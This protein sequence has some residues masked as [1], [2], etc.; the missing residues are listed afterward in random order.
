[1]KRRR[2][3]IIIIVE[4][5]SEMEALSN[6]I[7]VLFDDYY[8]GLFNVEFVITG[9]D[10][11]SE[12]G[13]MPRNIENWISVQCIQK[14]LSKM[15]LEAEDIDHIIQFTDLDGAYID[16]SCIVEDYKIDSVCYT[17]DCIRAKKKKD[18]IK[19]NERKRKNLDYLSSIEQFSIY[20]NTLKI[21]DIPYQIFFFSS[22]LDHF[23]YGEQNLDDNKK[24]SSAIDFSVRISPNEFESMLIEGGSLQRFAMEEKGYKESWDFAK[25]SKNSLQRL[26]NIR[27]LIE[28]IQNGFFIEE[29]R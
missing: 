9:G 23:L 8:N 15:Y 7:S 16:D 26:S 11:T 12:K 21:A 25:D 22:N 27:V 28:E 14:F 4:G 29:E 19:R 18:I 24:V 6:I 3:T 10:V 5:Q 17:E 1:M 13:I 20:K 2:R